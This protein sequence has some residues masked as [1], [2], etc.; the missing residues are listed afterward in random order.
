[1]LQPYLAINYV[2]KSNIFYIG[3]FNARKTATVSA[4]CIL[5][6]RLRKTVTSK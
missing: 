3:Q 6:K 4:C 5:F 2:I 1:M